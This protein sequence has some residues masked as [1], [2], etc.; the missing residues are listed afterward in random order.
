[1]FSEFD[2]VDR[3][4]REFLIKSIEHEIE[5]QLNPGT[6]PRLSLGPG[7]RF[8]AK[9][10]R[11]FSS[12]ETSGQVSLRVGKNEISENMLECNATRLRLNASL[13]R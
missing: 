3:Y 9:G 5:N 8:S 11:V 13:S 12:A 7:R 1:M 2:A 6:Y 10:A 4:S